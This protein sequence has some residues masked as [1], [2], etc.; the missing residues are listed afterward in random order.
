MNLLLREPKSPC[1]PHPLADYLTAALPLYIPFPSCYVGDECGVFPCKTASDNVDISGLRIQAAMLATLFAL[2]TARGAGDYGRPDPHFLRAPGVPAAEAP[3]A[4]TAKPAKRPTPA[5]PPAVK[6]VPLAMATLQAALDRAGFGVGFIDDRSGMRTQVAL[7]DFATAN[8][9]AE[10]AAHDLLMADPAPAL[11]VYTVMDDD[12]AAVGRA[13]SAWAEAAKVPAMACESLL[14]VLAE[15][16]HAKPAFL[17]QLNP[18][19][20][21][22]EDDLAGTE[23]RVPNVVRPG[24]LPKVT[25]ILIDTHE[26]R[27]RA[28]DATNRLVLSVP[29]SI[30]KDRSRVPAGELTIKDLAPNPTYTFDPANFPESAKAQAVGHKLIIPPGPNNPVGVCWLCL[31]L[32]GFGIHGTPHPETIG[33]MESHGCFRLTNWDITALSHLI[34]LGI[35]VRLDAPPPTPVPAPAPPVPALPASTPQPLPPPAPPPP[36]GR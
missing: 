10:A 13:P 4:T 36:T 30:A 16:F 34:T 26:F 7:R 19:V 27:L 6:R 3:A 22:W 35:P 14:E 24:K 23:I 12:L 11:V 17:E 15:K 28:Y 1:P 33:S 21:D 25:L 32:P 9:L 2:G 20:K 5:P 29:V 31:S 18:Q 8:G